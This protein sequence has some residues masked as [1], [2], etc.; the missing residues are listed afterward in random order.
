MGGSFNMEHQ[1]CE[2]IWCWTHSVT[3]SYD[4]DLGFSRSNFE[5]KTVSLEWGGRLTWVKGMWM[6]RKWDT[7]CGFEL[8]PL[9]W[10]W[11]AIFKVKF[12][13]SCITVWEGPINMEQKACEPVGCWTHSA[14][15]SYDLDLQLSRS[16]CE[17]T[18][19]QGW[20][21]RLTWNK[22]D[23]CVNGLLT[24]YVTLTF[25]LTHDL[26]LGFST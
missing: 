15:L 13:Q 12:W 10:P 4:L 6:D 16:N 18:I 19:S 1:G 20:E 2:S 5:K 3:V 8:W 22:R 21:G 14:T 24:N 23:V 25:N 11:N 9:T 26:G 17:I 7:H